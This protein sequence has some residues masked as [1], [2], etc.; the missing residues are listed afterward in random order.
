M[1]P[2]EAKAA[3]LIGHHA[4]TVSSAWRVLQGV[5]QEAPRLRLETELAQVPLVRV[6]S[7]K[8]HENQG[9]PE[10]TTEKQRKTIQKTAK[11]RE[12]P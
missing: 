4:L 11:N 6:A 5:R 10:K 1:A 3:L 12:K 8:I 9:K 7:N 2:I